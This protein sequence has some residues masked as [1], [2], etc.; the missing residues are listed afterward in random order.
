MS[1]RLLFPALLVATACHGAVAPG[2]IEKSSAWEKIALGE[3]VVE[4]NTWNTSAVRP[5]S[6]WRQSVFADPATDAM[7]WRWDFSGQDDTIKS[8]PE[9]IYGKKAF[10]AYASTTPRLPMPLDRARFR[11]EYDYAARAAGTYN[12]S[13]DITFTDSA[14]AGEK[15]VRAKLMIWF[16]HQ[17]M[18]F[19]N[20]AQVTRA[21]IAGRPHRVFIDRNHDDA[22]GKWIYIALL[23]DDLP[24]SGELNLRE[25]FEYLRSAGVL[26]PGWFLASIEIG[27]EIANGSGEITFRRFVVH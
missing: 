16:D 1:P 3:Y 9:I 12:T 17:N 19:F 4:N 26:Q 20:P 7:G 2:L 18:P 15:N 23:P 13:T 11:L 22:D 10:A 24:A 5:G 21:V 27:S 25:Y 8:F 6:V 14:Q